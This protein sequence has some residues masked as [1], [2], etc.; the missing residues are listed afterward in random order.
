M[1]E[2]ERVID[3][4]GSFGAYQRRAFLLVSLLETPV[5][6]AMLTPM[7]LNYKPDWFCPNWDEFNDLA[8]SGDSNWSR[9]DS[10]DKYD[11]YL[12]THNGS[13]VNLTYTKNSCPASG[14]CPGI[15]FDTDMVTVVTQVGVLCFLSWSL[16]PPLF[17]F[18]FFFFL[19]QP[20]WIHLNVLWQD[21][22]EPLPVV[23]I[24]PREDMNR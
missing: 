24:K 21:T 13:G 17:F 5:C 3:N 7:L 15:K 23:L 8:G 12:R 20:F 14:V 10:Y 22:S 18:F 16:P 9:I 19:V 2:Y 4:L 11:H 6:W 1:K